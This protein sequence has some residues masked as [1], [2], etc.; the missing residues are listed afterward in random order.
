MKEICIV[1]FLLFLV[2]PLARAKRVA[3]LKVEPVTHGGIRYVA[4]NDNGKREYIQA[5]DLET[6]ELLKEFTV[7]R[8]FTLFWIEEDVQWIYIR[9]MDIEGDQLI[10]TDEKNRVF[11]IKLIE[12]NKIK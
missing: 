4:P 3:P 6:G 2:L 10:V 8:N 5:F 12:K 7:K 9:K 1:F 11:K